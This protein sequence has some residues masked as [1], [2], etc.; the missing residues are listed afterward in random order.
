M[1]IGIVERLARRTHRENDEIVDLA[2]VLRFHPLVGIEGTVAAVAAR[3]HAGD[4]AGQIGDVEGI[5]LPG[6]ALAVEDALPCRFDATAKWRHH[7]EARD[8][9]PPH[10]HH[11]SPPF[12]AHN[13]KP[14]DR[15]TTAPPAS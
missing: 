5:D 10:I 1:P 8:D 13:K 14:A 2:L 15:P 3:D 4:P 12:A 6:A 11:S 7:A 9:N